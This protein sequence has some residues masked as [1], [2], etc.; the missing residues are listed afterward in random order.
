MTSETR[1]D[2]VPGPHS[3]EQPP[4]IDL[5]FLDNV[6]LIGK[7]GWYE[8]LTGQQV[9]ILL[10]EAARCA[11]DFRRVSRIELRLA[12]GMQ[13]TSSTSPQATEREVALHRLFTGRYREGAAPGPVAEM[14]RL[15]GAGQE[16]QL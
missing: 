7:A 15:M 16:A 13:D 9:A 8:P 3:Q 14:C 10:D 4:V 6:A 5:S 11:D 12:C 2:P 1:G